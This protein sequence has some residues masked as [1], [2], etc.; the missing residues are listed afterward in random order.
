MDH[1]DTFGQLIRKFRQERGETLAE[2]AENLT[3]FLHDEGGK[4]SVAMLSRIETDD[5][6]PS[7]KVAV[8]LADYFGVPPEEAL[9]LL[10][11]AKT[12]RQWA[13][14]S[15]S[16]PEPRIDAARFDASGVDEVSIESAMVLGTESPSA[17][18]QSRGLDSR[19]ALRDAASKV[20]ASA[21]LGSTASPTAATRSNRS[22]PSPQR[23]RTSDT[24]REPLGSPRD[25]N[26][27]LDV[28]EITV[29]QLERSA[30]Q[31]SQSQIAGSREAERA[32]SLSA[33]LARVFTDRWTD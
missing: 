10:A 14:S 3:P 27:L 7:P 24:L 26:D 12:S 22:A 16:R 17:S 32:A 29:R 1:F 4:I 9:A 8:A 28:V 2:L 25:L 11:I 23:P 6:S 20:R 18:R 15:A 21:A 19:Q 5:R 33:R 13:S 30:S 31:I